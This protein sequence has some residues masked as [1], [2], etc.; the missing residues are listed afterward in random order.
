M[1][2]DPTNILLVDDDASA[3]AVL[4]RILSGFGR[5]R[6]ATSGADALRM[7]RQDVPTLV[8]LDIEMPG[9]SGFDVCTA[10]KEDPLLRDVPVIFITGHNDTAQEVAGL[11]FGAVDFI[12]KP[13]TPPLVQARVRTQLHV[14]RM[15]DALR[16]A[17]TL[18]ALTGIANRRRVDD[19][20]PREC[21]RAERSRT[22]LATLMIDVDHFKAYND[23]YGHPAGDM[24]LRT[25]AH[26]LR[27]ATRRPGD[28][29]ARYGGE[30][31]V[32]LAPDTDRNG[33]MEVAMR[34]LA[35][36][37]AL[38]IPHD[39]S[40]VAGHVTISIGASTFDASCSR[41]M[42]LVT[43][44]RG[45][46]PLVAPLEIELLAAADR[47]LYIAKQNGRRRASFVALD[48]PRP[49]LQTPQA[50]VPPVPRIVLAS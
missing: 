4:G 40:P 48:D 25:V 46:R 28:L 12:S 13:P 42:P 27:K 38:A 32:L 23:H 43:E 3:I 14:K 37:D 50:T 33:V 18:D 17:A 24:V 44:S 22:P 10:M 15:G 47:A 36:I 35:D 31:F 30:E 1:M 9:L 34:M 41:W 45:G 29:L 6:F 21:L 39:A 49:A 11:T 26:A 7:A 19:E 5:L 8:L 16:D 2:N 20:I